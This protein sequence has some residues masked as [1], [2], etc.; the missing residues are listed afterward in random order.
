MFGSRQAALH[1]ATCNIQSC[2]SCWLLV[3]GRW[4]RRKGQVLWERRHWRG[5]R[6]CRESVRV[7]GGTWTVQT[8]HHRPVPG[9]K[10]FSLHAPRQYSPVAHLGR[11]C[12]WTGRTTNPMQV[13]QRANE[14]SQT[15]SHPFPPLLPHVLVH[16]AME[17]IGSFWI[18]PPNPRVAPNALPGC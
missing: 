13:H 18:Q 5:Q 6:S 16:K 17:N 15:P 7:L 11:G 1:Y 3:V 8:H 2:C 12:V 9:I 10:L 4:T 14:A